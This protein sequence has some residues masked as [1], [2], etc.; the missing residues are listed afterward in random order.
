MVTLANLN[1]FI[2]KGHKVSVIGPSSYHYYSG[3]GPGMLGDFYTPDDIRFATQQVVEKQG[4]AFVLGSVTRTDPKQKRVYLQSGESI[5]YDVLS[6]NAGSHVPRSFLKEDHGDIYS[7]KPIEKL[8]EAQKRI[9]ELVSEKNIVI[10]VVGGGP[11]ACEVA[12]NVW[13][14]LNVNGSKSIKIQ[15]FAGQGFMSH[16]TVGIRTKAIKSLEKRGVEILENGFVK[17]M[18]TNRILLESGETYSPDFI[19]LATGVVPSPI[20]AVSDLATGPDGGLRVNKYLQS[21]EYP[22]IFGGGDCIYFENQPLDKVGVYAVRQNPVL[23]HNLMA[24]LEGESLVPFDPGGDYLLIFNMG[25]GTGVL[26][27][28][29]L[30]YCGKTAFILK[31][32]I[33]RKFMKKF[34]EL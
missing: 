10:G 14:L 6:F 1:K 29:W 19:F 26:K 8:M 30:T 21:I 17:E 31:D 5:P 3:M 12:G 7:V 27:K 2:E 4:G 18:S 25:D 24:S 22:E 32:Y 11:A 9:L 20:F 23:Y 16:H 33:D 15:V 13:R 28:K 34:Q